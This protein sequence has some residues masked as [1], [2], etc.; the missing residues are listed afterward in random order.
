MNLQKGCRGSPNHRGA[1]AQAHRGVP[2]RHRFNVATIQCQPAGRLLGLIVSTLRPRRCKVLQTKPRQASWSLTPGCILMPPASASILPRVLALG[3]SCAP[4]R[5]SSNANSLCGRNSDLCDL[6]SAIVSWCG[7]NAPFLDTMIVQDLRLEIRRD[8]TT[9]I[10]AE[11]KR[12]VRA[13]VQR[14]RTELRER[15]VRNDK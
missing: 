8:G 14:G 3:P 1:R 4:L 10:P 12:R 7:G 11:L 13:I 15:Y 2:R 5:R 9:E 6:S